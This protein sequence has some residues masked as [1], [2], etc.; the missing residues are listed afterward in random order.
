VAYARDRWN[1]VYIGTSCEDLKVF[2]GIGS[3]GLWKKWRELLRGNFAPAV[4]MET[5]CKRHFK[6]RAEDSIL[7]ADGVNMCQHL[8]DSITMKQAIKV[9]GDLIDEEGGEKAR[10]QKRKSIPSWAEAWGRIGGDK[11]KLQALLDVAV[12]IEHSELGFLSLSDAA[13]LVANVFFDAGEVNVVGRRDRMLSL[14]FRYLPV[15]SVALPKGKGKG[16]MFLCARPPQGHD[17]V[18]QFA[19]LAKLVREKAEATQKAAAELLVKKYLQFL[20]HEQDRRVMKGLLAHLTGEDFV[21]K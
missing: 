5:R 6:E 7:V 16:G 12:A 18:L 3:E 14:V 4:Q 10:E 8:A 9:L 20:S 11:V 19:T 1:L 17:F 13:E 15:V 21:V 2:D